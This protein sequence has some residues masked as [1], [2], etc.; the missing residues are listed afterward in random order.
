M[1]TLPYWQELK[2]KLFN[3]YFTF[4]YMML[5]LPNRNERH[6]VMRWSSLSL[7]SWQVCAHRIQRFSNVCISSVF[8]RSAIMVSSRRSQTWWN[9][10]NTTWQAKSSMQVE[11]LTSNDSTYMHAAQFKG[12]CSINN[13]TKLKISI[14]FLRTIWVILLERFNVH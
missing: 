6:Y 14:E 2:C 13:E 8:G 11:S 1:L 4:V 12:A 3:Y 9:V 5:F 7:I 10:S